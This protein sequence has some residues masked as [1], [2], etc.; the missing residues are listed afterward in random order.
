VATKQFNLRLRDDLDQAVRIEAA[1]QGCK[2]RDLIEDLIRAQPWAST[3][4]RTPPQTEQLPF[5]PSDPA[6]RPDDAAAPSG[7]EGDDQR[8]GDAATPRRMGRKDA[9]DT[10]AE[11][12]KSGRGRGQARR[13][14]E[15]TPEELAG[16]QPP[17]PEPARG[18]PVCAE[19]MELHADIKTWVCAGCGHGEAA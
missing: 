1:R 16:G 6:H 2:P 17:G 15:G 3:I 11:G 10:G 14:P 8:A 12:A 7:A 4:A 19:D 5:T 18:C 13:A 9:T